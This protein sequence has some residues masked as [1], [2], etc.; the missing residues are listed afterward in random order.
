MWLLWAFLGLGLVV[1]IVAAFAVTVLVVIPKLRQPR[2]EV[3]SS[4]VEGVPA[5]SSGTPSLA[6]VTM[7]PVRVA[8]EGDLLQWIQVED[9]EHKVVLAKAPGAIQGNLAP[10]R[11]RVMAKVAARP[12]VSAEI[13]VA[14]KPLDLSCRPADKGHVRCTGAGLDGE[15]LLVP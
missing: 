10:G 1:S 8:S 11:Y 12:V 3:P 6:A 9:L 13:P 2:V 14:D 5:T 7:V 15:A 4:P